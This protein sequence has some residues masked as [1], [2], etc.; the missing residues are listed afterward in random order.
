VEVSLNGQDYTTSGPWFV[1]YDQGLV[2]VSGLVPHGGPLAGGT[3]VVVHGSSFVDHNVHCRFGNGAAAVL[4][5]AALLNASAIACTTPPDRSEPAGTPVE[6][7]LNGDVASHTLTTDGV[8]FVFYNASAVSVS[9]TA[10]L[11]G[12]S[13]GGTVVMINGSGFADLG[14]V[15]CRFGAGAAATVPATVRSSTQLACTSPPVP[16]GGVVQLAL[17]FNDDMAA[18]V[19]S[20]A[21]FDYYAASVLSVSRVRPV[22]GPS[23]GG[24]L[25]NVSGTG[26]A[27]LGSVFCRFG[28]AD[29]I[30]PGTVVSAQLVQCVSPRIRGPA[31]LGGVVPPAGQRERVEVSLNG[32]DYMTVG[33]WFMAYDHHVRG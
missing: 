20:S 1:A 26:F 24:T 15:H 6:V 5:R 8:L 33:P 22:G 21:S 28:I 18:F 11:G 32:Q 3:R 12:P 10:P 17:T 19:T 13:A 29:R 23:A 16:A 31:V 30:S 2:H 7:S 14:G 25:L 27:T 4:V 9:A